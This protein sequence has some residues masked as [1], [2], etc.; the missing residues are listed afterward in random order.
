MSSTAQLTERCMTPGCQVEADET[1]ILHEYG[2][3]VT[4]YIFIITLHLFLSFYPLRQSRDFDLLVFHSLSRPASYSPSSHSLLLFPFPSC[5]PSLFL[6]F[7]HSSPSS[8][9][10]YTP[11][12]INCH[13]CQVLFSSYSCV[14]VTILSI[15]LIPS[16]NVLSST[17][18]SHV[19]AE[20]ISSRVEGYTLESFYPPPPHQSPHL[21][22]NSPHVALR[23]CLGSSLGCCCCC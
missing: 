23:A 17:P 21:N 2:Y 15:I 18:I 19:R 13:Y 4:S 20:L 5:D 6:L 1:V 7:F 16:S 11:F 22:L 8:F 14:S 3:R 12:S 10:P 9:Q